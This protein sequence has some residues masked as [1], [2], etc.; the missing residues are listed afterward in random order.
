MR[1]EGRNQRTSMTEMKAARM[2]RPNIGS[3]ISNQYQC[4]RNARMTE[5]MRIPQ[6][7]TKPAA[8]K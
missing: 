5:V 6:V 2:A 3:R 4:A 8:K 1:I 7:A